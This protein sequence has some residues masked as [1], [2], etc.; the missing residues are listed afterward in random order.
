MFSCY[1]NSSGEPQLRY[2]VN[3]VCKINIVIPFFGII[4]ITFF[5]EYHMFKNFGQIQNLWLPTFHLN[6]YVVFITIITDNGLG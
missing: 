1:K 3:F 2:L 5:N 6:I 4:T